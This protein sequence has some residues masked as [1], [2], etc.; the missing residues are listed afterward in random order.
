MIR[1]CS[2]EC[3][4][5]LYCKINKK[6]GAIERKADKTRL[7]AMKTRGQYLAEAQAAF[8]RYVR[9]RDVYN[10]RCCVSSG[11]PLKIDGVGGGFDAGHYRSVGSANHLRFNLHNVH[12]QS[13]QENRYKQGNVIGYRAGL[14][15]RIGIDK[16]L[17]LES[18]NTVRKFSVEYLQ[19]IKSIFT[20]KAARLRKRIK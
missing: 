3:G 1:H 13:K 9:L 10:N 12:G 19:R 17:D 4:Y 20:K 7:S 11:A 15:E 14:I 5:K 18:N 16:V 8:N 6:G 2:P